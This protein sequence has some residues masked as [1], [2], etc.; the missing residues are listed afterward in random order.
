[1]MKPIRTGFLLLMLTASAVLAQN[2]RVYLT[3]EPNSG[4]P[5]MPLI[6]ETGKTVQFKARAFEYQSSGTPVEITLQDVDWTVDPAAFGTITPSGAFT[7]AGPSSPNSVTRGMI[8]A[9]AP[10]NGAMLQAAIIAELGSSNPG[11][12]QITG[13]VY[14]TADNSPV[15]GASIQVTV[16]SDGGPTIL[17]IFSGYTDK[18][19]AYA[20]LG[21]PAGK[22]AVQAIAQG[23]K[24]Q[25]Y[26]GK[27]THPDADSVVVPDNATVRGIDFFLDKADIIPPS[28]YTISGTVTDE[29]SNPIPGATITAEDRVT[30][31]P[32]PRM[33]YARTD[34]NGA[35]MLRVPGM[36]FAIRADA[37]GFMTEYYDGVKTPDLATEVTP[38]ASNPAIT[39]IDF[40]LGT[41]GSISGTVLDA[42]DSSPI[43][44]AMVS[45]A[46]SAG[47]RPSSNAAGNGYYALT[48]AA[49]KYRITGLATGDYTLFANKDGFSMKYYNG[50]DSPSL[51]DK[52][53]VVEDR[54]TPGIDF[55]L[56]SLPSISGTVRNPSSDPIPYAEVYATSVALTPT[57]PIS[58]HATKTAAD[59]TYRF[60]LP[61]GKYKI[62]AMAK[63][64]M[65]EYYNNKP[66]YAS[67]DEVTLNA[68]GP[69]V[70]GIDFTLGTGGA[71]SGAVLRASDNTPVKDAMVSLVGS[72][73]SDPSNSGSW[74]VAVRTDDNG[75]Y[76]IPGL[77]AGEYIV[78]AFMEG[79]VQQYYDKT[80]DVTR[81]TRV[82]VTSDQTTSGIDFALVTLPGITGIVLD[83]ADNKPL[84]RAEVRIDNVNS[85]MPRFAAFTDE[86]GEYHLPVPAGTYKVRAY[87]QQYAPE[88]F[89]GKADPTGADDVIVPASGTVTG[90]N[91]TLDRWGGAISGKV[92]DAANVPIEKAIV[93]VWAPISPN[94]VPSNR[95]AFFGSA[96]TAAD[97]SYLIS[98]LPPG[99][100]YAAA[101]ASGYLRQYYDGVE[102]LQSASRIVVTH[103]HTASGIDFALEKGG[104]ITG[105]VTDEVTNAPIADAFVSLRANSVS[106]E[107]G[108]RTDATGRYTIDG[109]PSGSYTVFAAASKYLA[110]FY[111]DAAD[112]SSAVKVQVTAPNASQGIDFALTPAPTR[113]I[114]FAGTVRDGKTGAPV[115]LA[116]I[117]GIDPSTGAAV[118][119]TTD[120]SGGFEL[121]SDKQLL[122]RARAIGYVG[123]YSG[124]NRNWEE[125]G[126]QAAADLDFSL[127]EASECGFAV[128]SGRVTESASR[129]AVPNAW[130]YGVDGNGGAF[131][132]V[133]D[134][135]GDFAMHGLPNGA[136]ELMVSGVQY[137]PSD[138]MTEIIDGAGNAELSAR[139]NDATL[140][141]DKPAIPTRAVLMQNYPNP[142]N[143][144][145]TI[146]YGIPSA[147]PVKLTVMNLLG[148]RI[149]TVFEGT[150]EA[151]IHTAVW[152]AETVPSGI[153]LYRLETSGTVI[154]RR[155][156]LMK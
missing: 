35:Y 33:Y 84:A 99:E 96:E 132:A 125:S 120:A 6:V 142:F 53:A 40:K 77:P 135:D 101:A 104:S 111:D 155:M 144:S 136:I 154:T 130:V 49:G 15:A 50:K 62:Q 87:A 32:Y 64:Y 66:D 121:S 123:M 11:R 23:Y 31:G 45:L 95:Q 156:T 56:P 143:P 29:A 52:V 14:S 34:R 79:F 65:P 90:I 22:Y 137:A 126:R 26:N 131:F 9:T 39:G 93:K 106:A 149:A 21:L 129:K 38:G 108:A 78:T 69:D 102:T 97:G 51:A 48:D 75:G 17:P 85:T 43:E 100:Y 127:D 73:R 19:G 18:N 141:T 119:T 117:E 27:A 112:P 25:F 76:T 41:G 89:N 42:G 59:G 44:G 134:E 83:A 122:I 58:R 113:R 124:E 103:N 13:H 30:M 4:D 147:G 98:G 148:S 8:R 153:Y 60:T 20:V 94:T 37:Q 80:D 28:I 63:G 114:R 116:L 138:G 139:K 128:L 88:W 118:A 67:A 61:P 46:A 152:N 110:E 68:S 1:M 3:I 150:V 55:A 82:I 47:G 151:G 36:P 105:I 70:S 71:I 72:T 2:T 86:K 7:P 91:F 12:G 81:A 107:S 57:Q 5:T 10:Y 16:H 146:T 24:S 54:D 74:T 133:S 140:D 92:S 145:T 109:L 115:P